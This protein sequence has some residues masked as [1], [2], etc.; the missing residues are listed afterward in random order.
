MAGIE[1]E[2]NHKVFTKQ[3]DIIFK[4]D[5]ITAFIASH[6][7]PKNRGHVLIVPND[8]YE[9][10]Y[11]I[12]TM[13]LSKVNEFSKAVALAMKTA[14]NCDGI[15]TRQHNGPGGSQEV[16]HYHLHVFPRYLGDN[17]YLNDADKA[18]L[19][20]SERCQ[21]AQLLKPLLENFSSEI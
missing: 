20:E 4:N 18:F 3:A 11:D 1:D 21:Y 6:Q 14:Y 8:H 10:L 19:S 15:S 5:A 9:N 12:P 16:W 7:W 13:L 2:H 17:L